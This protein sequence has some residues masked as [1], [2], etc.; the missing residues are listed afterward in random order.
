MRWSKEAG[1]RAILWPVAVVLSPIL[2]PFVGFIWACI[3]LENGAKAVAKRFEHSAK[4]HEWFAWRPVQM[5]L[6]TEHGGEW[7]WMETIWRGRD[8]WGETVFASTRESLEKT[9]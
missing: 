7:R 6:W 8:R 1:E 9:Q 4:P 5:C 2:V 3:A